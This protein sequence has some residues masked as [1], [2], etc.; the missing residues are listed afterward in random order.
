MSRPF[1]RSRQ[2]DRIMSF[3]RSSQCKTTLIN[4]RRHTDCRGQNL[5][6]GADRRHRGDAEAPSMSVRN[7]LATL[8]DEETTVLLLADNALGP[9]ILHGTFSSL[10]ALHSL[11]L[12][13]NRFDAL[14][15]A[16]MTVRGVRWALQ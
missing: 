16:K 14:I 9:K 7:R 10:S 8:I 6:P 12:S 2:L 1:F 11:D 15:A 4:G 3:S 5:G 13:A